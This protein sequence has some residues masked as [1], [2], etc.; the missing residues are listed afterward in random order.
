MA[1]EEA[2]LHLPEQIARAQDTHQNEFTTNFSTEFHHQPHLNLSAHPVHLTIVIISAQLIFNQLLSWMH[3]P[4]QHA[5][6]DKD[7]TAEEEE[8]KAFDF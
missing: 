2:M 5:Q 8:E 7:G 3:L 6:R 4:Q 1:D